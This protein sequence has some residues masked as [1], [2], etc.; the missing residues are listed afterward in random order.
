MIDIARRLEEL[1]ESGLRRRLRLV[2]GAQGPRVLLDGE[3]VLLLCS[4][5]YLGLASDRRVR[6]APATPPPNGYT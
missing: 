6:D 2:E 3:Q 5:D 4:N 1:G